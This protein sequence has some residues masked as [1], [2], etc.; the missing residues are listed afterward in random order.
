MVGRVLRALAL[1]CALLGGACGDDDEAAHGGEGGHRASE[2]G[3]GG[4]GSERDA[5][6][7]EPQPGAGG[8]GGGSAGGS[9]GSGRGSAAESG[10]GRGGAGAGGIGS[11]CPAGKR[12]A[13]DAYCST[14]HAMCE[15]TFEQRRESYCGNASCS[16]PS[17]AVFETQSSCGGRVIGTILGVDAFSEYAYYDANGTLVGVEVQRP[18]PAHPC[19]IF[20]AYGQTCER[21]QSKI[22]DCSVD[23]GL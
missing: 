14:D 16:S 8:S 22:V 15:L 11:G 5:S 21:I 6:V 10:G 13:L 12:E 7:D 3:R 17:C 19:V 20:D 9:G 18:N 23:A 4:R 1:A 2:A